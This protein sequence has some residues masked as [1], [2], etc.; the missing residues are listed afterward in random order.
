M[1][2]KFYK[3]KDVEK[4]KLYEFINILITLSHL[5]YLSYIIK[6]TLN[7][8]IQINFLFKEKFIYLQVIFLSISQILS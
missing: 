3:N 7:K 8:Y 6:K 4:L 5:L 2:F 1:T